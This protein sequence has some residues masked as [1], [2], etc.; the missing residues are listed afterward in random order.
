MLSLVFRVTMY[1]YQAM[2]KPPDH[3]HSS[4]QPLVSVSVTQPFPPPGAHP[5]PCTLERYW[6]FLTQSQ[7]PGP[8]LI[9]SISTRPL[10]LSLALRQQSLRERELTVPSLLSQGYTQIIRGPIT[11]GHQDQNMSGVPN[12]PMCLTS[13]H[14]VQMAQLGRSSSGGGSSSQEV[15]LLLPIWHKGGGEKTT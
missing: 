8:L 5:S 15:A 7:G 6:P 11:G 1:D 10:T 13:E 3:H 2:C 9:L 14:I 4:A 12:P